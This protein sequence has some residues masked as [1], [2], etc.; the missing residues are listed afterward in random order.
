MSKYTIT[1]DE[2]AAGRYMHDHPNASI[3]D[4][5]G[6]SESTY[7]T[8]ARELFPESYPMYTEGVAAKNDFEKKFVNHFRFSEIGYSTLGM[9][10]QRLGVWLDE[11]MPY[12]AQLHASKIDFSKIFDDTDLTTTEGET[13]A[14]DTDKTAA[15]TSQIARNS[16]QNGTDNTAVIDGAKKEGVMPF[17]ASG[18]TPAFV[19]IKRQTSE[20]GARN[21]SIS[22]GS[23]E[24]EST[25][26]NDVENAVEQMAR[27]KEVT[28]KG[29]QGV[30]MVDRI[31]R[32]REEILPF[33]KILF[34][35]AKHDL[36][37]LIY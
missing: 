35:D 28:I 11:K 31:K 4:V 25:G 20:D 9:F 23:S 1:L 22:N 8:Y 17:V 5:T 18:V 32:Y 29:R 27:D 12:F 16:R 15:R 33:Y 24:T 3:L 10:K 7:Q 14:R 37:L 26:A 34:D 21:R 13:L 2:Y 36:F 19:D 6:M 30:D